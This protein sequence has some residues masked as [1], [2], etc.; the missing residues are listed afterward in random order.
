VLAEIPNLLGVGRTAQMT[1]YET[2][3]GARVFASGAFCLV[4]RS[5]TVAVLLDNLWR[6]LSRP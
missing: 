6:R 1:Y 4:D 3:G 5:R 2:A